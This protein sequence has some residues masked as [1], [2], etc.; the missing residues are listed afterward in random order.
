MTARPAPAAVLV[1]VDLS[2]CSRRALEAAIAWYSPVAEITAIHVVD[3]DLARRLDSMGVCSYAQA[4][5]RMRTRAEGELDDIER[6]VAG[7]FERMVVEGVPFAE[8]IK[9]AG[10]LECDLIVIGSRS[11]EGGIEEL[12]FGS[13]AEKVLR[14]ARV[15]VLCV[16]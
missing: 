15:P 3:V 9:I 11:A 8:I 1:A 4:V 14:G 12:L 16:P 6:S 7:K 5:T 2:A 10:D 13:T